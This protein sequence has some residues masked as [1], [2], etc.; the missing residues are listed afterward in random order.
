MSELLSLQKYSPYLIVLK[1]HLDVTLIKESEI[2]ILA[3]VQSCM[4]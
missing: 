2:N 4:A 3:N 1:F